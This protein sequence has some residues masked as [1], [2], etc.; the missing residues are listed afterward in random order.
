MPFVSKAQQSY[1]YAK[2]PE[3]A[4]EFEEHTPKSAYQN[5]PEHVAKDKDGLMKLSKKHRRSRG[6]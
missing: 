1:L 5:L 4:K 3:V 2:K 6:G